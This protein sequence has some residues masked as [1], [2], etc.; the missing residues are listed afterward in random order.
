MLIE[1]GRIYIAPPDLHVLLSPGHLRTTRGPRE[2]G[3][4][5]S[6]NPL[7]RS[8]AKAYGE[9]V[10]SVILTGNLDDG[11]AGMHEVKRLG[12]VAIVQDPKEALHPGMPRSAIDHVA[13][14]H[15]LP[16]FD[17]VPVIIRLVNEPAPTPEVS[18]YQK[19]ENGI[20]IAQ[21]GLDSLQSDS[22]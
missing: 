15:V 13:V 6:V 8:A 20:G 2:N 11:T 10:I 21:L 7:F 5:P 4:R 14:D 3:H 19:A 22:Q 1:P 17:I 9:K 16:L 12:G 18:V